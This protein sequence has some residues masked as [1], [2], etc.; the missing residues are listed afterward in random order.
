MKALWTRLQNRLVLIAVLILVALPGNAL[1]DATAPQPQYDGFGD[2]LEQNI[3]AIYVSIDI[4]VTIIV[5]AYFMFHFMRL[6]DPQEKRMSGIVLSMFLMATLL[7]TN[8]WLMGLIT[9]TV[10]GETKV[11]GPNAIKGNVYNK[12][13]S[14]NQLVIQIF[15]ALQLI[16]KIFMIWNMFTLAAIARGVKQSSAVLAF[17]GLIA[18]ALLYNFTHVAQLLASI[19]GTIG[20]VI[21]ALLNA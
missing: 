4:L 5:A 7:P 11:L 13:T 17:F 3:E 18:S 21:T 15:L 9:E 6:S 20:K 16:G 10:F 19:G 2:F 8:N 12:D 14:T 1:A